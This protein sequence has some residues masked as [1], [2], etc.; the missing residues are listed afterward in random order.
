MPK[1]SFVIILPLDKDYKVLGYY[2]K[3]GHSIFEVTS[4]I[5][6]RLNLDHSKDDYNLLSLKGLRLFSYLHALKGKIARKASNVI[7][8]LLLNESDEPEKFRT[9]LKETAEAVEVLG[10]EVLDMSQDKF[11]QLLKDIYL[12]HLEP[13]TDI[14]KPEALRESIINITKFMLS[15][16]KKERI[17]AQ[18]LLKRVENGDHQ[19]ISEN[20]ENAEKALKS[21]DHE[22][23]AKLFNKASQ[24]AE[25]LYV[26]DIAEILKEKSS[27]SIKIPDLLKKRNK[28]V[29]DARN[30]LRNEDFH[31]AYV[32]Y[33]KASE[34]SKKLIDFEKEEEYRLKSKALEDFY[35][36]DQKKKK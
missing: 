4:D 23:A 20:Y 24:I 27:F 16:G 29:Q 2:F 9:S 11:E 7:I 22:K 13:L 1:G 19:K 6:L 21:L 18:D 35:L 33:K 14:L 31:S 25:E 34:L 12:E 30:S 8:G 32:G 10:L 26:I 3:E 15:G 28:L 17:I 5:F 36:V